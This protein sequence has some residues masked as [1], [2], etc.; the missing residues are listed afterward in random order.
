MSVDTYNEYMREYMARRRMQRRA[1]LLELAGKQCIKC[2]ST[3]DLEFDHRD[4]NTRSF[5]LS[6]A[7]LDGAW[8]RILEEFEKC[9]LLCNK[10][11]RRKTVAAGETGGGHNK[12]PLDKRTHGTVHTYTAANC[13]CLD[14]R[15]AKMLYRRGCIDYLSVAKAP[16]GWKR[17][18]IL[19]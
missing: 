16:M 5:R 3:E 1:Q 10:C 8:S 13:R 2:E 9:D 17:G 18:P 14:C 15:F 7:G 12:I 6:G 4:N 19:R 11:H